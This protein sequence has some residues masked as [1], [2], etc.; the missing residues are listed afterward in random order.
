MQ[1]M[2]WS[3]IALAVAAGTS[4]MAVAS[5]QSESKGFIEDSSF[6]I[7]NRVLYMNRDFRNGPNTAGTGDNGYREETGLGIRLL[8]E[9]GFTQGTVGVGVDAHSLS[10]IKIDSGR[11]RYGNG[12]FA[13]TDD[14]RGDDTQTEVG[15]AIKFRIS[16]TVLKY[17]SQFTASPV[18]STDDSRI[19]PE[20]ATGTYLVSNEIEGLELSAGRFTAMSSQTGTSRDDINGK[21]EAGLKYANIV[22][23]SYSFN[24]DLSAAF[25]ASDVEDY[26]KKYYGNLNYNLPLA[27]EQALNFDFNIYK[28]D[29]DKTYTNTV[30]DEDNTI[31]SLAAAYSMGAHTFTLAHQR[32]TGDRG[33]DYGVDGGGTIWLSNSVQFSDFNA[34]D[35]KSWQARYDINMASYGVPGLSF[36]TRYIRGTDMDVGTG[37]NERERELDIEAKYVIQEGA[38][39]DLSFRVRQAFYRNSFEGDLNDFRLIVEYPLSVL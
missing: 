19:L 27:E 24:D 20:V 11:G 29:Y 32:S 39:K 1:V 9:S 37:S 33:Y 18:F 26:W 16:D 2:K 34:K 10:S 36:M 23:A 13:K 35:E 17:G 31:W 14:G 30:S 28:T 8:Y 38:A 6:N 12:L 25:H 22:G 5:S 21:G 7:F 3:V 15:G 4:Q